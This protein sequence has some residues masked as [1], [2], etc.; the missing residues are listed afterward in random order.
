MSLAKKGGLGV[1]SVAAGYVIYRGGKWGYG[2]WKNRSKVTVYK[3]ADGNTV[4]DA[5]FKRAS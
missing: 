5:E 4:V 2:K 1:L 3:D